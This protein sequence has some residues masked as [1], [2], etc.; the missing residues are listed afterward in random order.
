MKAYILNTNTE[1]PPFG[2]PVSQIPFVH[3]TLA[4]SQDRALRRFGCEPVRVDSAD[5]IN[6]TRYLLLFDKVYISERML[7]SFLRELRNAEPGTKVLAVTKSLSTE[8][9]RALQDIVEEISADGD[10]ILL[11]DVYRVDGTAL[12]DG[13]AEVVKQTLLREAERLVTPKREG[14]I[15]IRRP[16][17]E[18]GQ[19]QSQAYIEFPLTS[20][21]VMHINSWVHILWLN[22]LALGIHWVETIRRH[23]L[24]LF[25]VTMRCFPW[26]NRFKFLRK[27]VRKGKNCKIHPSAYIEGCILGDNVEVGARASVRFSFIGDNVVISD[28]STIANTVVGKDAFIREKTLLVS[29]VIYPEAVVDNLRMQMSVVGRRATISQWFTFV[30]AK[31]EGKIMVDVAGGGRGAIDTNFLGSCAGHEVE[32]VGKNLMHPGR[33]IP[34]GYRI[35]MRPDEAIVEVPKGFPERT[36]LVRDERGS[37]VPFRRTD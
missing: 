13:P 24:W 31:F 4:E 23:S 20:S 8:Q 2:D 14:R 37:L 33:A 11:Y 1:I 12:P 25:G 6:D 17:V 7:R 30:D 22:N 16:S 15:R 29:C 19:S 18:A 34:N 26:R 21:V 35:T 27:M 3:E 32:L 28:G 10:E 36:P 9:P 5:Q